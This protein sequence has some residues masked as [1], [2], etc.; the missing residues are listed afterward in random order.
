VF[1]Q[2]RL[3]L[4][5]SI[6]SMIAQERRL[7]QTANNLANAD[8]VGYKKDK[9]TFWE[10]LFTASSGHERVGKAVKLSTDHSQGTAE[11]TGNPLDLYIT[12]DGYFRVQTANG[13]R[14]TRAG[15]FTLNRD[16]QMV[17]PD[18]DPVLGQGGPV[19]LTGNDIQ[20]RRDG[21]IFMDGQEVNRLGLARFDNPADLEKEGR[22]LFRP[23]ADTVQERPAD[24]ATIQQGF[25]ESSNVNTVVEMTEMIDLQRAFETQ[26]KMIVT[27][28]EI[29]GQAVRKVGSLT[30]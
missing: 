11:Q 16:G 25:R 1:I 8:T 3:G 20:I 2:N 17:T 29:D 28:D 9:V 4:T 18:G 24:Q 7:D 23:T 30:G 15:N 12:G 26:Q 5:E 19:I 14:Y 13:V 27:M 21:V 22:N 10:M 6:E